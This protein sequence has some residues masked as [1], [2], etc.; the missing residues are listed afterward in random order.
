MA[1]ENLEDGRYFGIAL[2]AL[3]GLTPGEFER[4][5]DIRFTHAVDDLGDGDFAVFKTGAGVVVGVRYRDDPPVPIE[6]YVDLQTAH[7]HG[8]N[9]LAEQVLQEVGLNGPEVQRIDNDRLLSLQD[10][11]QIESVRDADLRPGGVFGI[12]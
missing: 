9:A 5:T 4:R 1:V 11:G 2:L 12:N 10:Y 8:W 6:V 3:V 7:P